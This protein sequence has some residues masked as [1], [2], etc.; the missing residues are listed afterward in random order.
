MG[1]LPERWRR[2]RRDDK[3]KTS[4]ARRCSFLLEGIGLCLEF[5][6]AATGQ[7]CDLEGVGAGA[8]HLS[9]FKILYFLFVKKAG[10]KAGKSI[11]LHILS[12]FPSY[13]IKLFPEV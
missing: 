12:Y 5:L 9:T 7:A 4:P 3:H 6:G 2:L 1:G 13:I 11:S 10:K 8:R